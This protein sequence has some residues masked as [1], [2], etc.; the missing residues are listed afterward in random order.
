MADYVFYVLC[1]FMQV[2]RDIPDMRVMRR[3]KMTTDHTYVCVGGN[4][5]VRFVYKAV[6]DAFGRREAQRRE[7]NH[8]KEYTENPTRP[9]T[10]MILLF[11]ALV[12]TLL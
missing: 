9:P 8:F 12:M 4:L 6:V 3:R 10:T 1:L 2:I 7:K 5:W 11:D